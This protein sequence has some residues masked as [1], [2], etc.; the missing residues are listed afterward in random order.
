MIET[1][2]ESVREMKLLTSNN[3]AE[4]TRVGTVMIAT[5]SGENQ[6]HGSAFFV[7]SNNAFNARN[8]FSPT[9]PKGPQRHEFGGS[10]GGPVILPGYDGH[11][12]TFFFFTWEHQKFP[13][14]DT[15]TGNVPTLKM[16][17]GDFSELLP[18]TV[19]NDPT[20]GQPFSGNIIPTDRIS[21]VS[22]N[23][24]QFGF[25]EPNYGPPNE[26]SANWR[27][28]Y[29][30]SD[31]NDRYV[32][33]V[34]H[35]LKS[36]D[37]LSVRANI[38]TIR[39][40]NQIDADLPIFQRT[41]KRD[42]R[43]AYISETHTFSPTLINEF[44]FG[45]AR[46]YSVLGGIHKGAQ[47]ID[48]FGLQG[49]NT[50]NKQ[51]FAGVPSI[52]FD[53]FSS[54]FEYPSYFWMSE[55]FEVLDNVTYVKGKHSI[56]TGLLLRRSRANI[57]ECCESDFGT[58]NFDGFATGFD[59]ADFLLGFPHSTSRFDRSSPRYN[60][61]MD[62]GLFVQDDFRVSS[63][64]TLNLGLRYDYFQ[65]P[66]D[67]YD[68]RYGFDP[69]TGNLVLASDRSKQLVSPLFPSSI[70][71][72]TAQSAGFPSRSLL[73]SNHAD[74]SP[75][76]GFAYQPFGNSRTIIRGGYGIYY[77][78]LAWS[79]MDAFAGG[80]FHSFEDFLN[81]IS[82]GVPRFQFPDPFPGVGEIGT[83]SISPVSKDLRTPI[84]QQWNF[85][86]ERELPASIVA[87]VTYRGFKTTQI[88]YGAD[89]NKP[90]P[91]GDPANANFF[92][93]PN[94]YQVAFAQDG[95]IQKMN[96]LDIGVERKFSHGLTF[97]S[98]WTWAK[99][100]TDVGNDD[101]MDWIENP[102][103]RRSEMANVYWMPRHKF[104]SE[105]LYELPYGK[106][107]RFGSNVPSVVNQ[108]L[109]NWQISGVLLFQ[110]G[111]FR[112]PSFSGSD[113]SNTRTEGGRPDQVNDPK[114]ANPTINGWFNPAAFVVPPNGR[115]GNSARG[116][117]VGPGISNFDFGLFKYFNFT[118]KARLQIRMT[119]T[120][121]FNHPNYANP[122]TNISS[123]NVGKITGL[124]GGRLDT[125]G[126]GARAI[127]LG[128]RVDF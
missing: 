74:F 102:Y 115:F 72:V 30:N 103:D 87:R 29:P 60:R 55:I 61:Y 39:L 88:P 4:F 106:G 113:P 110:T 104:V 3:S 38:R 57:S 31:H 76:I 17:N 77:S 97:Q 84:T 7:S 41:Q 15:L 42:T 120:N 127:Q 1:P 112:T 79:L 19:I 20:T 35:Q 108:V 123:S 59:Y 32:V 21:S 121:F 82:G 54:M 14:A 117:I 51:G 100:M 5:R 107:K 58:L 118:E 26:F 126:A 73:E 25:L 92:R 34:D 10:I 33:R 63:K 111:Q 122:N 114:L 75:R 8:T 86:I 16:R 99:N 68:M 48:Q 94:F 36:S 49:I 70:P 11:N 65:P 13:G 18:D 52:N 90:L 89:I 47:L 44:R 56:K 83:Q 71:L 23:I 95:G 27:G 40:P 6:F 69:T 93:Y 2:L 80:P 125:L 37:T 128:F 28:L 81:D 66:V 12:R 46:D 9:K 45:Y 85:T 24:Q 43:N 119:A 50:A 53:N 91:S 105:A 67:K 78:R 98:G 109:G 62:L 22:Q 116:V 96:G 101:E 124:Q 64:L